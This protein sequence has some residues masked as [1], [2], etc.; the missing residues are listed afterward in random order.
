[1][2]QVK[3]IISGVRYQ[4]YATALLTCSLVALSTF[5]LLSAFTSSL[6]MA[7]TGSL[8]AFGISA[9]FTKLFT[10]KQNEAVQFIHQSIDDAEY[11]L[12]L[13]NIAQP[14]IAEQLQLERL[15]D[16]LSSH[17]I[18]KAITPKIWIPSV[19]LLLS[20]GIYYAYPLLQKK[21]LTED[22]TSTHS[23][24]QA[25]EKIVTPPVFNNAQVTITPPAYTKLSIKSTSELNISAINGSTLKWQLEFSHTQDL[26]VKL[27]N[28]RGEELAFKKV[29]EV[30]EYTDVL[31]G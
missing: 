18:P 12:H 16:K 17:K 10:D 9:Y 14:N 31:Q 20:L 25:T 30:F 19:V 1:M 7:L 4:L 5:I 6:V 3:H 11:S 29:G 15:A 8:I 26:A 28:N 21:Q 27:S 23:A 24:N 13:L 22:L 2:N